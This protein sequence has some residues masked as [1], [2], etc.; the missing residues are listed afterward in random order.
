MDIIEEAIE[1]VTSQVH[2]TNPLERTLTEAFNVLDDGEKEA[3]GECLVDLE[4]L[5]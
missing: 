5:K 4:I 1:D 2:L 3:L